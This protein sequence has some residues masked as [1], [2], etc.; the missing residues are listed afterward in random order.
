MLVKT[1]LRP[2]ANKPKQ[3][4]SSF[5]PRTFFE[6]HTVTVAKELL[7][8]IFLCGPWCGVITETEAYHGEDDPACHAARGRTPRTEIMY[9]SPGYSYVYFIY[10]MHHCLNVVTGAKNF[11]SAVLIRGV[12]FISPTLSHQDGPGKLCRLLNIRKET[13][14]GVD[15]IDNPT[16]GFREAPLVSHYTVGPRVGISRGQERPWRFQMQGVQ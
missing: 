1:P 10:G 13:H 16:F 4:Y 8:K 12:R 11:P 15:M 9:G 7:G 5:L 2:I 3:N 14:N 6:R